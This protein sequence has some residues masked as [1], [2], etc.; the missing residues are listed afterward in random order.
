MELQLAAVLGSLALGG[1][2]LALLFG[3]WW[4]PLADADKRV[5]ELADEVDALRARCA[6]RA[7]RRRTRR[8][9]SARGTAP[10]GSSSTWCAWCST[11]SSPPV[12]TTPTSSTASSSPPAPCTSRAPRSSTPRRRRRRPLLRQPE[13]LDESDLPAETGPIRAHLIGMLRFLGDC[14]AALGVW[15]AGGVGKSTA[16]RLVR[17]VCGRVARFDHV[18]VVAASRD[19]TVA[20]LQKEVVAVLG[21]RD[22]PTEQAQAAGILG[23]LR[24]KSFLLLLDGVWDRLDLERVGIPQPLGVVAGKVRKVVVASRSEAVCA[25]MGCR[26]KI[27]MECWNEDDAWSLFEASVGDDAIGRHPQIFLITC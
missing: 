19:C 1:A 10:A 7:R 5:K 18:L 3:K 2:L 16:L 12:P 6:L 13:D 22:A 17:E 25:D 11:S 27:K 24:D 20:K 9:P 14:D 15:G 8:R 21:L 23:F 26:K 4:Q